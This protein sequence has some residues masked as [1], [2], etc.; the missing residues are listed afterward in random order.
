[1]N[2]YV[3][4]D[5]TTWTLCSAAGI[6]SP[7]LTLRANGM[8]DLAFRI[9]GDFLATPAFAYA[10]TI[11]LATSPDGTTFTCRF[12]GRITEIP[13]SANG[14]AE[15]LFY[16][17]SGPWWWLEQISYMQQF[18]HMVDATHTLANVTYPRVVLGQSDAGAQI[19][20]GAQ[21]AAV[22]DYA[23]SVGAP[24]VKGT[25]DTL[26]VMPYSEHTNL[27]C[28]DA[29]RQC[30]RFFPDTVCWFDY[31]N[32]VAGVPIPK[33]HC[34]K[35]ANLSTASIAILNAAPNSISMTP[36]YDLQVPGV[37]VFYDALSTLNGQS[38]RSV[39]T[40][41]AGTTTDPR[42]VPLLWELEGSNI[43]TISQAITVAAYPA[44]PYTDKAFW[45]SLVPFLADIADADLVISSVTRAGGYP[46]IE[47]NYVTD[48]QITQWMIDTHALH[49][50]EETW[51]A[52]VQYIRKN[53]GAVEASEKK[54]VRVK[55]LSTDGVTRTYTA[56]A[57]QTA[58]ESVPTGI[59]A[60]LY[61]SWNRLHWDGD[62]QLVEQDAAFSCVP[63]M[64][65]NLTGGLTAWAT[66]NAL[67]QVATIDLAQGST[68]VTTGT[69]GR[70]EADSLLALWRA[71]HFRRFSWNRLL[72]TD[73]AFASSGIK[74]DGGKQLARLLSDT[75]DPGIAAVKQ[76]TGV[77]SGART[78]KVVVDPA[79][80]TFATSGNAAAL[81]LQIREIP[82]LK[83]ESD[84]SFTI[85]LAQVLGSAAYGDSLGIPITGWRLDKSG[86]KFQTKSG[87]GAWADVTDANG[88]TLDEGVVP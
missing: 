2:Y 57:S 20:Y 65:A 76:Y 43:E 55:L 29:I 63:G 48:G 28:A 79:S 87:A 42:A 24:F 75:S 14:T 33:M 54:T 71:A 15:E 83:L 78:Q 69:C 12:V 26:T 13:R 47:T 1:M 73:A 45:R 53:A 36:R 3:S 74:I 80:I 32:R 7:V 22:I 4:T 5:G 21:I 62:F 35:P 84:G 16:R 86:H 49:A 46:L 64:L 59:A 60:A 58:G 18:R 31:D 72:R 82:I 51:T 81:T 10:S 6:E 30:L 39:S 9:K 17:A 44:S 25:I 37:K 68:R 56:L 19:D 88:G 52:T 50:H 67:V 61:A 34:R 66:M 70:L 27:R 11:Y 77:D 40:D 23:V 85:R 8:D 41:S 38:Y